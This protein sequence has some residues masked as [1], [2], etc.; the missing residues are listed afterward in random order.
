MSL[1]GN[2]ATLSLAGFRST[3]LRLTLSD[4]LPCFSPSKTKRLVIPQ[5]LP[6]QRLCH[7]LLAS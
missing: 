5:Y 4:D 7:N 3:A 1:T 2:R 6:M